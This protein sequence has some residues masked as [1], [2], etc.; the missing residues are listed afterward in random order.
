MAMPLE[1]GRAHGPARTKT[2]APE[3][4]FNAVLDLWWR[5][6]AA[7]AQWR[8]RRDLEGLDDGALKDIGV[9]RGGIEW[10]AKNGREW[11]T[12]TPDAYRFRNAQALRPDARTTLRRT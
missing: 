10:V 12:T 3:V 2:Y 4:L 5:A 6:M 1:R 8:A 7:L 9:P 11:M